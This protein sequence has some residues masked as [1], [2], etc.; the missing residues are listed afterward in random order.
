MTRVCLRD[1]ANSI[2]TPDD[3]RASARHDDEV[4]IASEKGK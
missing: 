4:T 3:E 2:L 1:D